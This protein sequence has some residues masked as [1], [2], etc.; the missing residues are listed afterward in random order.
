MATEGRSDKMA[1]DIQE[2]RMKQRCVTEFLCVEK[3][4]PTACHR[5][6]LNVYGCEHRGVVCGAFQQ[7]WQWPWV[8]CA[9]LDFD[10]HDMQLLVHYWQ[11]CIAN[12]G[13]YV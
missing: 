1:P 5:C 3:M 6:L 7:W 8:T 9:G 2:V 4:A 11:K 10:E 13:D 12:G